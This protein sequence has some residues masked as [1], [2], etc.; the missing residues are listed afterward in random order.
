[1]TNFG[2]SQFVIGQYSLARPA[3]RSLVEL[4]YN[5]FSA[6]FVVENCLSA[7]NV[8]RECLSAKKLFAERLSANICFE[9]V[10]TLT[11][12]LALKCCFAE[13][14]SAKQFVSVKWL[15]AKKQTNPSSFILKN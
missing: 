1:M 4:A 7:N 10:L 3:T 9:N 12:C 5:L 11:K 2:I 8:F 6:N 15:S 13:C 14:L